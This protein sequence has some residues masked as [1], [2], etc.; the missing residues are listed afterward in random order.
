MNP[1]LTELI[2]LLYSWLSLKEWLLRVWNNKGGTL[3]WGWGDSC[4][5]RND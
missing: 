1:K 2:S 4:L 5:R 3:A